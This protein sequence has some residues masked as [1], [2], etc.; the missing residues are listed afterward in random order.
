MNVM[1]REI[2]NSGWGLN[3]NGIVFSNSNANQ[4]RIRANINNTNLTMNDENEDITYAYDAQNQSIIRYD[5]STATST[6]LASGITQ[7]TFAYR[8]YILQTNGTVL[9]QPF[10]TT[11]TANTGKVRIT[12]SIALKR[13]ANQPASTVTLTNEVSLRNTNFLL[14]G[15]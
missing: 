1:S 6:V 9:T 2:A 7:L 3:D 8:D 12:I 10:G 15:Y 14:K 13:I 5:R 4:L 11:P